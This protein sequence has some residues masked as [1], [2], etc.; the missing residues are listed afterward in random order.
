MSVRKAEAMT[1]DLDTP[2]I[3]VADAAGAAD[4]LSVNTL[5]SWMQSGFVLLGRTDAAAPA[6]GTRLLSV[7]RVLQIAI[8]A[9]LVRLHRLAPARA[10]RIAMSFSD[11][12]DASPTPDNGGKPREPGCVFGHPDFTWLVFHPNH[13]TGR[14]VRVSNTTT[15]LQLAQSLEGPGLSPGGF[16]PLDKIVMRVERLAERCAKTSQAKG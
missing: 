2:A 13:E 15:A 4:D 7:R 9:E 10:A 11:I 12:S 14:V 16:L 6:G 8:M 5:R 1:L 3:T